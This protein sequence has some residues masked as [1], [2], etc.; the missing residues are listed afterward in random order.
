M[1]STT[2]YYLVDDRNPSGYA[3]VLE[4]YQSSTLTALY[5]YGLDLISQ[6]QAGSG[7]TRY[8]GYDGHGSTRFLTDTGGSVT[9][10]YVY[11]AYGNK[12]VSASTG[13]SV[14]KYLYCGEQFDSDLNQ[15]YL[16][17]RY[18]KP[19]TGRFW[20]MDTYEVGLSRFDWSA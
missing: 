16:R 11:D 6:K 4:E 14:N 3:Q 5:N 17:A 1:G 19:D 20:T 10:T 18:Y 8:F 13:S 15:Y 2:T 9:D 12:I 7:V